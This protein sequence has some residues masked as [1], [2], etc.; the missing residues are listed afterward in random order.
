MKLGLYVNESNPLSISTSKDFIE[1]LKEQNIKF[2][3]IKQVDELCDLI[4]VFG[5]DG[6]TVRVINYAIKYD[7]PA[8]VIN[9]GTVGFFSDFKSSELK[10]AL[11]AILNGCYC[12]ERALIN[13]EYNGKTAIALNDVVIKRKNDDESTV[14]KLKVFINNQ[15]VDEYFADGLIFS[16]PTGST[17]Y[18]LSAGG[19]VITPDSEVFSLTPICAHSFNSRSIVYNDKS[20]VSVKK[21]QD[22]K[23]VVYVDGNKFVELG[24]EPITITKSFSR[25]KLCLIKNEFFKRLKIKLSRVDL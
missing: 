15:L 19:S 14:V 6:T 4:V 24:D 13:V 8:I 1:L 18:S 10:E 7:I 2:I 16:T 17:A 22:S 3:D 9:T 20:I 12:S 11:Q 23:A 21:K 25:F 5:G